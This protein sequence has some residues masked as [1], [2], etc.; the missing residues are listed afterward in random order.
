MDNFSDIEIFLVREL[1]ENIIDNV[2]VPK[3]ILLTKEDVELLLKEYKIKKRQLC[4]INSDDP[5][6]RY[7]NAK[8]GDIF[9]I[10]RPSEK[11]GYTVAY[12][13]VRKH[14]SKN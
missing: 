4:C 13:L 12:R 1:L 8:P 2:L 3:H 6:S 9:R 14:K 7:Y 5:I 10:E 11:S